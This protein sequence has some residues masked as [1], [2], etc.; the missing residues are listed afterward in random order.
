ML[1]NYPWPGNVREL[2]NIIERAVIFHE[3]GT[4]Y[5]SR[6]LT[7]RPGPAAVASSTCQINDILPLEEMIRNYTPLC[8]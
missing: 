3:N 4:I 2:K 7:R 8:P 5:P 6:L 1:I